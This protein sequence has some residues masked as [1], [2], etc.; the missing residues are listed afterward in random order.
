MKREEWL[1]LSELCGAKLDWIHKIKKDVYQ[2][3]HQVGWM[4]ALQY[5]HTHKQKKA[6]LC[7]GA[8]KERGISYVTPAEA[9]YPEALL[10]FQ[11]F[12]GPIFYQGNW[13]LLKQ[14]HL[15]IA[16][17]R[18][19]SYYGKWVCE[20]LVRSLIERE[21]VLISGASE[22]IES[23]V[24]EIGGAQKFP[25]V[26][27]LPC[28]FDDM[29]GEKL[30]RNA[31]HILENDGLLLSPFPLKSKRY[32]TN[33]LF[34][35]E[36][37]AAVI[38]ALLVIEA[39]IQS[40]VS[41]IVSK[42]ARFGIDL[43]AVPGNINSNSSYLPNSMIRDGAISVMEETDLWV[44]L[45]GDDRRKPKEAAPH[46]EDEAAEKIYEA[47]KIGPKHIDVLYQETHLSIPILKQSIFTMTLQGH[48]SEISPDVF[49][50]TSA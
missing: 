50:I 13:G 15:G 10:A 44:Y 34:A 27:V 43:L 5:F 16:G 42:G 49:C 47:L 37:F 19:A 6:L 24:H 31:M 8:Y 3:D 17:T 46:F 32:K 25:T 18:K 38:K 7:E 28:A 45:F 30:K 20:K 48:L 9:D 14:K 33:Y 29:S 12:I 35:N 26:M 4:Q 11:S 40:G 39:G 21:V 41:D 23:L 2:P 22:G 36:L 1:F